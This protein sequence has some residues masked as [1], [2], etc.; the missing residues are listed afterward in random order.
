MVQENYREKV[1][2]HRQE[3]ELHNGT[4][5]K[6]SRVSRHRK[7][8]ARKRRNPIMTILVVVFI[9]IPLSIL[10]Y[11]LFIFEPDTQVKDTIAA[12][13][14]DQLVEIQ[15]QDPNKANTAADTDEDATDQEQNKDISEE[16]AKK[17]EAEKQLL[18]AEE[19][20][21][22]ETQKT[23][24][25]KKV[26]EA[27]EAQK[28]A[29]QKAKEQ[30]AAKK[31]E[32]EKAKAD[33][34]EAVK[35]QKTHTVQSTDNLYRIALKYYGNGSPTYIEKIKAANNLSSDSI[36]AGQVLVINP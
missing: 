11:V 15:K 4:A 26:K 30:E 28:V 5:S 36:S 3:I 32:A 14:Q 35:Q 34:A 25:E 33:Q 1:E 9:F 19:A 31:A 2:E 24:D 10:V 29:A 18:A 23:A 12:V 6:S 8:G 22:A 17:A 13:E 27:E 21:K 7:S 16:D 20:K